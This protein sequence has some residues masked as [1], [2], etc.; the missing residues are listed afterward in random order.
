MLRLCFVP[1]TKIRHLWDYALLRT[2]VT[3]ISRAAL[4]T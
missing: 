2:G 3:R 4:G 1:P